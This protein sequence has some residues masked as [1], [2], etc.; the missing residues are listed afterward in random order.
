VE[1][2]SWKVPESSADYPAR[3]DTIGAA[4]DAD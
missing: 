2:E 1:K 4:A 3:F